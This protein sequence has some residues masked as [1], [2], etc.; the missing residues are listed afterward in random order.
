MVV[1]PERAAKGCGAFV[2]WAVDGA[3]DPAVEEDAE[4]AFGFAVGLGPVGAAA[5]VADAELAAADRARSRCRR[6]VVGEDALDLDP[7]PL[8]RA[9]A[10]RRKPTAE[11]A[12]SLA[13]NFGVGEAAVVDREVHVIPAGFTMDAAGDVGVDAGVVLPHPVAPALAGAALGPAELS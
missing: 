8:H 9:T 13:R 7:V 3:V 2:A 6:T 4:D 12:L 11:W 5:E 1:V 10:R